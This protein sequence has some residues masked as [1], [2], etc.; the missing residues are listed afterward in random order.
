[1]KVDPLCKRQDLSTEIIIN[2]RMRLMIGPSTNPTL[3]EVVFALSRNDLNNLNSISKVIKLTLALLTVERSKAN[4][5][6]YD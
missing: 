3:L 6:L 4:L 5:I 1:M 2:L